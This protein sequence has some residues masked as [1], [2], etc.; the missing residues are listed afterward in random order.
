MDTG[1]T[2]CPVSA[3]RKLA[4]GAVTFCWRKEIVAL[5]DSR[6]H[7][8]QK[9]QLEKIVR[10]IRDSTVGHAGY[11]AVD[12]LDDVK[13]ACAREE[14]RFDDDIFNGLLSTKRI[15]PG[16]IFQATSTVTIG[17]KPRNPAVNIEGIVDYV[18]FADNTEWGPNQAKQAA[19]MKARRQGASGLRSYLRD[20]YQQRGSD[21]LIQELT[22]PRPK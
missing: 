4:N 16:E 14:V 10:R 12:F 5:P 6:N 20:V 17:A 8:W 3:S 7:A 9:K 18:L 2:T 22:E 1:E 21:A 11:S 15:R 19:L 13:C